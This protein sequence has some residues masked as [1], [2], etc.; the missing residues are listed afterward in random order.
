MSMEL[1][2]FKLISKF[3][4]GI[5]LLASIYY[6]CHIVF[7]PQQLGLPNVTIEY[8]SQLYCSER[9]FD[10]TEGLHMKLNIH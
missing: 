7:H 1:K 4:Y 3:K 6:S 2:M 10:E 9:R 5:S 8:Q